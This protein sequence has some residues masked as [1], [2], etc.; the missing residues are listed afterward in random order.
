M[1]S[2]EYK[3][4]SKLYRSF[5]KVVYEE[6]GEVDVTSGLLNVSFAYEPCLYS[7]RV[8]ILSHPQIGR[9]IKQFK[10]QHLAIGVILDLEA[11]TPS[12]GRVVFDPFPQWRYGLFNS[13]SDPVSKTAVVV[14][15]PL[16][17][18]SIVVMLHEV[19]HL[20]EPVKEPDYKRH[21]SKAKVL[22]NER[23]AN[24]FALS[25][26]KPFITED[27]NTPF[28]MEAVVSFINNTSLKSHN[29]LLRS[30]KL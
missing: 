17:Y 18:S 14:G 16:Q 8:G 24:D 19:G 9:L 28:T 10:L 21:K 12:E 25:I 6:K 2:K 29:N 7:K 3:M 26:L 22:E 13:C 11:I 20:W 15:D 1:N 4:Y 30:P 27:N 5:G 23:E